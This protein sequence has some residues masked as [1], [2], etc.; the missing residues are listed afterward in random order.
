MPTTALHV[1][2]RTFIALDLNAAVRTAL[3][4]AQGHLAASGLPLRLSAP[5]GIH[6]TLAFIGEIPAQRVPELIAAVERGAEGNGPFVLRAESTGMFPNARAPRVVWAGVQG[7]AAAMAV[8]TGLRAGIVRELAAAS[9]PADSRFDPHLTLARVREGA[10]P[11]ERAAIGAMVQ[12]LPQLGPVEF[13]V[14]AVSVMRSQMQTGG[15]VYTQLAAVPL[16]ATS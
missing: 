16:R 14:H 8:L 7:D 6:L 12:A 15:S 10:S 9:F 11:A 13:P 2:V 5:A 4:A 3:A 1:Q